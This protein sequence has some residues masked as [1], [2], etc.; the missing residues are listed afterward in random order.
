[1]AVEI[2]GKKTFGKRGLHRRKKDVPVPFETPLERGG[3]QREEPLAGDFILR[4]VDVVPAFPLVQQDAGKKPVCALRDAH[5]ARVRRED[6]G[7]FL[8]RNVGEESFKLLARPFRP[9]RK[10]GGDDV[11][12]RV[13]NARKRE[14]GLAV[15]IGGWRFL[16]EDGPEH[17]PGLDAH[18]S[19][20]VGL[21]LEQL[22]VEEDAV[23]TFFER[24]HERSGGHPVCVA[25]GKHLVAVDHAGRRQR[26]LE[27]EPLRH[28]LA[29]TLPPRR[30]ELVPINDRPGP[31]AVRERGG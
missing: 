15:D 29:E 25:H 16:A 27:I 19:E 24:L 5:E 9:F 17:L 26:D 2:G 4:G 20:G 22:V 31:D 3:R 23:A 12:H 28:F 14:R 30:R 1:M 11:R 18:A 13:G 21:L 6:R 10:G 8:G 7:D